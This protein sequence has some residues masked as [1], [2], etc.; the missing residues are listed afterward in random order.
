[1]TDTEKGLKGLVDESLEVDSWKLQKQFEGL[2]A[3]VGLANW[4]KN[5]LD[6][7]QR[8]QLINQE[9]VAA[10]RAHEEYVRYSETC[11]KF[12]SDLADQTRRQADAMDNIARAIYKLADAL[13]NN[14]THWQSNLPP[15]E[16]I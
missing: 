12:Q 16:T 2:R 8:R 1:M 13:S 9:L 10:R 14:K 7:E 15:R 5:S 6:E 3:K 4:E 11:A